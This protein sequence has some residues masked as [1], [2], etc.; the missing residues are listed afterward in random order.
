MFAIKPLS[1][2][3]F[4]E[5]FCF[6]PKSDS[7]SDLLFSDL[8]RDPKSEFDYVDF[9]SLG[10]FDNKLLIYCDDINNDAIID[11]A[12]IMLIVC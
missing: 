6:G 8:K 10:L 3:F 2:F 5:L 12:K 1:D 7:I 4:S 11:A 9:E